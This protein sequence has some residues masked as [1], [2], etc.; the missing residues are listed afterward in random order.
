MPTTEQEPQQRQPDSLR[1]RIARRVGAGLLIG[2][3]A[4]GVGAPPVIGAEEDQAQRSPTELRL[5][6]HEKD[7][8]AALRGV[9]EKKGQEKLSFGEAGELM[10]L[11]ADFYVSSLDTKLTSEYIEENSYI[12]ESKI[13]Q[14][15]RDFYNDNALMMIA[16][17]LTINFEDSPLYERFTRNYPNIDIDSEIDRKTF[18][19]LYNTRLFTEFFVDQALGDL[20]DLDFEAEDDVYGLTTNSDKNSFVF[21]HASNN[22]DNPQLQ[23]ISSGECVDTKPAISFITASVHEDVHLDAFET[24]G[25]IE[26]NTLSDALVESVSEL[27]E[28]DSSV[29]EVYKIGFVVVAK[30]N[31]E[32]DKFGLEK[33]HGLDEFV[34]HYITTKVLT[35]NGIGS[36]VLN[37]R[38][39]QA[40][41]NFDKI[42]KQAGISFAELKRMHSASKLEEFLVDIAN[43]SSKSENLSEE[44]KLKLGFDMF[45]PLFRGEKTWQDGF[46]EHYDIDLSDH[47]E[48]RFT[49]GLVYQGC[50]VPFVNNNSV[51]SDN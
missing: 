39:P 1:S 3:M 47:D 50:A 6:E 20:F 35:E 29:A 40:I 28:E 16:G 17:G 42:L 24:S 27:S 2:S 32:D 23:R 48:G 33:Y 22:S 41:S 8:A 38:S 13:T 21:L 18:Y 49:D 44:V 7:S 4:T 15:D 51:A 10:P 36:L 43:G 46:G 45:T 5:G 12:V 34:T 26:K 19:E 25:D 30:T 9:I 37:D 31:K 14:G 11:V